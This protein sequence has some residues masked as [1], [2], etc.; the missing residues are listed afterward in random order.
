MIG[1]R[2]YVAPMMRG[3]VVLPYRRGERVT[4]LRTR[5][6]TD[7][8]TGRKYMSPGGVRLYAGG[9]PTFFLHDVLGQVDRAILTEGEIKALLPYQAWR[10]G[11]INMPAIATPGGGYLPPELV[12]AC[13][14]T[15]IYLCYDTERRKDPFKLSPGEEFTVRNGEKLRGA[16]DI[17]LQVRLRAQLQAAQNPKR[18]KKTDEDAV[19]LLEQKV[20]E[21]IERVDRH[22]QLGIQVKVV[23]L[24]RDPDAD[25]VD[26]DE[27]ILKHGPEAL[28]K[29]LDAA[30]DYDVWAAAHAQSPY[31]YDHG[32]I[33]SPEGMAANYQARI[34]EE[35]LEHDGDV[36]TTKH[37]VALRAPGGALHTVDVPTAT[38]A[39]P[40]KAMEHLRA[41]LQDGTW[42]D[43]PDAF[44]AIKMLSRQGDPPV[45][46]TVYTATGWQEIDGHWHYLMPDGAI[47]A[48][49]VV[50]HVRAEI[51]TTA[52][53]NHYEI[54]AGGDPKQGAQAFMRLINGDAGARDLALILAG[55]A[56]H[57]PLHR[58]L[59]DSGRPAVYP[60][61]ES[62]S[63]KSA[64]ARVF[65]SLYGAKFT[66]VK[67]DGA[68]LLKWDSTVNGMEA[69]AYTARDILFMIDDYKMSTAARDALPR[70]LHRYSESTGR[71]RMT[72]DRKQDRMYPARG[73]VIITG[74]DRPSGDTGQIGRTLLFSVGKTE[75]LPDPLGEIQLV[76]AQGHM[77][78][79]WAQYLQAIASQLDKSGADGARQH[80]L[81]KM[82]QDD[83][84]LQAGHLRSAGALRQNRIGW[85][86]LIGWMR[87]AKYITD[88]EMRD[89]NIAHA[90]ARVSMAGEQAQILREERPSEIFLN[91][92]REHLSI[93]RALLADDSDADDHPE[94]VI[95]FKTEAGD[96]ALLPDICHEL[97][98]KALGRNPLGYNKSAIHKQLQND[99]LLAKTDTKV[100]SATVMYRDPRPG[101][102]GQRPRVLVIKAEAFDSGVTA[103]VTPL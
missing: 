62:G 58:F 43:S 24:P 41:A 31:R 88:D 32:G 44:R 67:G 45:S 76:G 27:F 61:G 55:Q 34:M 49:G 53:G 38:W 102:S 18:G 68:A 101:H 20:T 26:L 82:A 3:A 2:G 103:T 51:D 14:G 56:A 99:G 46:R 23:R 90:M 95:G 36:T 30:P 94:R 79:F 80:L 98:Q 47:T 52:P 40:R 86:T 6:I 91:I 96:Y 57:A 1:K 29:L 83:N 16:H 69:A 37:R 9:T 17:K 93:K 4:M 25:K 64:F 65:L 42:D 50:R 77:A 73:L 54:G 92:L 48:S 72:H 15:T 75:I 89:L 74:E 63:L 71:A 11:K 12:A 87:L 81:H 8:G 13:A 10:Q 21:V 60:Y 5:K 7:D 59:R 70:F 100:N 33:Y 66:G 22:A 35:L 19:A 78:A 39:D 97:V 28:Q 85:L 84:A